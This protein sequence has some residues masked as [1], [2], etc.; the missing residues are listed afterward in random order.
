MAECG[1]PGVDPGLDPR[2]APIASRSI[3]IDMHNHLSPAGTEPR[4]QQDQ[5]PHEEEQQ[6]GPDPSLAEELK[7]SLLAAV[8]ASCVMDFGPKGK[9]GAARDTL[10][11]W[12]TATDR[13]LK[14]G[15]MHRALNLKD[16]EAAHDHRQPT[17]AHMH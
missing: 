7:R 14:K 16:L 15:H 2:V 9:P 3:G 10:R 12:L 1:G 6:Q 4:R 5:P 11:R 13:Q 8:C 17:L